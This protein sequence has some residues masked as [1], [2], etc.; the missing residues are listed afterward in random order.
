MK[1]LERVAE[2]GQASFL[3]VLKAFGPG[4][5]NLLSFPTEGYTLALDLKAEPAAF[6]LMTELDRLV[7]DH[8]GRLYLAKDA[9]MNEAMFKSGYPLWRD[10]EA[11]RARYHAVGKFASAQSR[12]L[13]LQ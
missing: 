3:A 13:G 7:L 10:F 8:G 2:A 12:R 11:V 9:R 5:R 6:Q 1:I 4:N